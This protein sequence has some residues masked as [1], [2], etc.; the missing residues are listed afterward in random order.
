[1]E[2]IKPVLE[3][4]KIDAVLFDMDGVLTATEKVHSA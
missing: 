4:K 2:N 1:M 3:L